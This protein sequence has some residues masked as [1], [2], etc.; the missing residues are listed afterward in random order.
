[1]T[2]DSAPPLPSDFDDLW[3]PAHW[4]D[5]RG[6]NP[7]G[8]LFVGVLLTAF[9]WNWV[10]KVWLPSAA[11]V[12]ANFAIAACLVA[13]ARSNGLSWEELGMR[14]DR[15]TRGLAVGITAAAAI[16]FVLA[17]AV[18]WPA[19]RGFFEDAQ[20]AADTVGSRVFNP[21]VRIPLGTVVLE[22]TLFRGV[23][24]ALALRR[25]SVVT[26]VTRH[27]RGLWPVARRADHRI[28]R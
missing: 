24:L 9:A 14:R 23:L 16:L 15:L 5:R 21:L 10:A 12:P 7:L 22:E 17:I 28:G 1:M 25:W 4:S 2:R 26:A 3:R 18:A 11:W 13:A 6:G 19:T 8:G 20:V 27:L